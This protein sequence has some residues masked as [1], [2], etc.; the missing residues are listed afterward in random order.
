LAAAQ[1]Q[2]AVV[3]EIGKVLEIKRHRSGWIKTKSNHYANFVWQGGFSV[4]LSLHDRTK[5]YI[6]NQKQHHHKQTYKEEY[7]MFIKEYGVEYDE[8]YL[9]SE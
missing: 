2:G 6:G 4:S 1:I 8:R 7:T 9:W 5:R 3:F